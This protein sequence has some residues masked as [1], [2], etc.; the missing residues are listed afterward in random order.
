MLGSMHELALC[1]VKYNKALLHRA[2]W[3]NKRTIVRKMRA[4]IRIRQDVESPHLPYGSIDRDDYYMI[5]YYKPS[6]HFLMQA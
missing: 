4:I 6:L 2:C 1:L 5:K 3:G